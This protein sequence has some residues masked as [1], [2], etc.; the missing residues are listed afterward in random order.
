MKSIAQVARLT[1]A[2]YADYCSRG[3]SPE[4]AQEKAVAEVVECSV[5]VSLV[6]AYDAQK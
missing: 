4:V 6:Q 1:I 5:G 3:L 2:I